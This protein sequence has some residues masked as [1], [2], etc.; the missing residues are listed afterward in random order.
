[1]KVKQIHKRNLRYGYK[2][3]VS[4]VEKTIPVKET[5][6]I[7]TESE[8]V[9]EPKKKN[10]KKSKEIDT[11]MTKEQIEKAVELAQFDST[12]KVVKKDRGLIE[13]TESSKVV[14]TE[15]NRMVLND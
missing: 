3:N 10:N 2:K 7:Q 13:R 1:M 5:E 8:E 14:L 9:T 15:D 4:L 6:T 11:D 12:V